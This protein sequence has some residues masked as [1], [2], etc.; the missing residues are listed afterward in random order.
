MGEPKLNPREQELWDEQSR[1]YTGITP[2]AR[3]CLRRYVVA[4]SEWER[5]RVEL[6]DAPSA[7]R[8]KLIQQMSML[9]KQAE[10]GLNG[11][12]KEVDKSLEIEHEDSDFADIE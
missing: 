6:S 2:I 1:H 3:A 9:S 8:Y 5:S 4:Q 10:S 11:F 12:A 7:Q